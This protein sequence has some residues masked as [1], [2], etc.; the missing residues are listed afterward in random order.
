MWHS[1]FDLFWS[2]QAIE[3]E[4]KKTTEK[5]KSE[6]KKWVFLSPD[7]SAKVDDSL[8]NT[9]SK[10][11]KKKRKIL[12]SDEEDDE[13]LETGIDQV[14]K[15]DAA[16]AAERLMEEDKEE[17]VQHSGKKN[18]QKDSDNAHKEVKPSEKKGK[19]AKSQPPLDTAKRKEVKTDKGHGGVRFFFTIFLYN[20]YVK[21]I[22][23]LS[24][25][26]N[27][28]YRINHSRYWLPHCKAI[29]T[30]CVAELHIAHF[31]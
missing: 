10:S 12:S 8:P 21:C 11:S 30:D 28:F 2:I 16:A 6:K 3:K 15:L 18:G 20:Y 19:E 4:G 26:F 22:S 17:K 27:R 25:S 9:E 23:C 29:S 31:D 13:D 14:K 5:K 7:P 24:K 1:L